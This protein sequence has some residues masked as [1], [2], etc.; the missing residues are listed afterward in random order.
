MRFRAFVVIRDPDVDAGTFA[1]KQWWFECARPMFFPPEKWSRQSWCHY[2]TSWGSL[3]LEKGGNYIRRAWPNLRAVVTVIWVFWYKV[4]GFVNKPQPL[5]FSCIGAPWGGSITRMDIA[6]YLSLCM[7]PDLAGGLLVSMIL[8][9]WWQPGRSLPS[10]L[11]PGIKQSMDHNPS[12][13]YCKGGIN[14]KS[15]MRACQFI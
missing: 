14:C 9:V 3:M 12:V 5:Y 10:P 7:H 6:T 8:V 13:A 1:D 4:F 2:V 11:E 15:G